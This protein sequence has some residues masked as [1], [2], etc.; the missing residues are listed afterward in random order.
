MRVTA[1]AGGL[2]VHAIAGTQVV[3]L[4]MNMAKADCDGLLGFAIHRIDHTEQEAYWLKGMRTFAETDPGVGESRQVSSREHPFQDFTWSDYTA[5]EGRQ[6]TY[7][8]VA[9][10]GTPMDLSAFA[11][12]EVGIA[13]ESPD[14]GDHD[15]F[16]N[17]GAAASQEYARRFGDRKPGESGD[18][19]EAIWSWLSRGAHEAILAFLLRADS[20]DWGVRVCAYEFRLPSVAGA[21]SEAADRGAD[22]RILYDGSKAFP[23]EENREVAAAHGIEPFCSE[24]VPKPVAIPHNKFIV[25]T[26]DGH[27]VAVLTGSTN[28]STGGVFGQSNVVHIVE[29]AD[30][31]K[32][33]LDYW[34]LLA[35]NPQ[36]SVLAPDPHFRLRSG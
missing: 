27:A 1:E 22:V 12:V 29:Q 13:T 36:K 5:K 4:A 31:A 20:P 23:A 26:R 16:F 30:V 10:K 33:Y 6:Y 18:M 8:V 19:D 15:V 35:A 21:I 28:F 2:S 25:L 9:L 14:N 11:E 3:I 7:R 32:R 24:R 17:R 34:Q